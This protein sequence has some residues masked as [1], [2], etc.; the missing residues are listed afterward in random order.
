MIKASVSCRHYWL[1][2]FLDMMLVTFNHYCP[3]PLKNVTRLKIY[4]STNT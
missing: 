2:Q 3:Y 4:D 1:F